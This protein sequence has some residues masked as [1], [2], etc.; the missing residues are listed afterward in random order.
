MGQSL[1]QVYVHITF[2]TKNRKYLIDDE[3]KEQLFQYLGGI[4]K[5]LECYP[6]QVGGVRD[7]VYIL[8]ILLKK[9]SQAKLLEEVKKQSSRW[10]KKQG[11]K[12]VLFYWQD[13]L[14][15]IFREPFRN[16]GGC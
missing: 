9:I 12:Y 1:S 15:N 10:M 4:C 11:D 5:N 16:R 14:W 6:V 2:S 7:H 13:G 3:I 8:C